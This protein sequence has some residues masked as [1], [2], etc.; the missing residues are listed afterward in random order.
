MKRQSCR[1]WTAC[2]VIVLLLI[3]AGGVWKN[4]TNIREYST[5]CVEQIH[6]D[7]GENFVNITEAKGNLLGS[8]YF[9]QWTISTD[10]MI[11]N[12]SC[13][14][15]NNETIVE[16]EEQGVDEYRQCHEKYAAWLDENGYTNN[17]S[18]PE[19]DYSYEAEVFYSPML[20]ACLWWTTFTTYVKEDNHTEIVYYIY[21]LDTQETI[22]QEREDT[23]N[24]SDPTQMSPEQF[25]RES[26]A[27][28][29]FLNKLEYYS[30]AEKQ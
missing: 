5:L 3:I 25:L 19:V 8:K 11:Y 2:A 27:R 18:T 13:L 20:E 26:A 28:E 4:Q 22:F 1:I 17:E 14:V 29:D 24:L 10:W 6:A 9:Y 15:K 30:F 12:F 21:N 23:N 7:K 16:Y